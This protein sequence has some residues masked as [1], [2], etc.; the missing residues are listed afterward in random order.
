MTTKKYENKDGKFNKQ[1]WIEENREL[2][3]RNKK[4]LQVF[5]LLSLSF[6]GI[7]IVF[8]VYHLVKAIMS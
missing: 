6:L 7:A 1:K 5:L 3:N 8:S 2:F 4:D